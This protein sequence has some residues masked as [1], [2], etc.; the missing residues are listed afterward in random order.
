M[1]GGTQHA[2]DRH[3]RLLMCAIALSAAAV[4]PC[5]VLAQAEGGFGAPSKT[6]TAES[7]LEDLIAALDDGV[8]A[9]R[10]RATALLL[11]SE[12]VAEE[13]LLEA[14]RGDELTPEQS[15]RLE[16]VLRRSF[17]RT[18]RGAI[19]ISFEQQVARPFLLV[20]SVVEGFPAVD[21]G[22]IRAGDLMLFVEGDA[23]TPR[24]GWIGLVQAR[25][26]SKDPGETLRV[27]LARPRVD[28]APGFE[29]L[30]VDLPLGR[31]DQ[32]QNQI[33]TQQTLPL[34]W[35]HRWGRLTEDYGIGAGQRM[36]TKGELGEE[37]AA[38]ED[39]TLDVM[40]RQSTVAPVVSAPLHP[41]D[42]DANVAR[43]MAQQERN[44]PAGMV[45]QGIRRQAIGNQRIPVQALNRAERG[46]NGQVII[47]QGAVALN[48]QGQRV[49]V[50]G[51]GAVRVMNPQSVDASAASLEDDAQRIAEQ[52][53]VMQ[54]RLREMLERASRLRGSEDARRVALGEAELLA[55]EIRILS[56]VLA[57]L[58]EGSGAEATEASVV[59]EWPEVERVDRAMDGPFRMPVRRPRPVDQD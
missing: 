53:A 33:A 24:S 20:G 21:A 9:V 10:Q 50:Q 17:E 38:W 51:I 44:V 2:K 37:I 35:Q 11:T 30:D 45:A 34:A 14:V 47:R 18:P 15:L 26:F 27:T 56:S 16:K 4:F 57:E 8:Y 48:G 42:I 23:I 25:T 41:L 49:A 55:S 36:V 29:I 46:E 12:R 19:G 39:R 7:S 28:L 58:V 32:H 6:L 31:I 40:M 13:D 52:I 5:G 43:R 1:S 59:P 22:L 3:G 54:D